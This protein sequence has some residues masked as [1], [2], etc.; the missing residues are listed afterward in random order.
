MKIKE[1]KFYNSVKI[2]NQELLVASNVPGLNNRPAY[3]IE[4]K[5]RIIKITQVATGEITYTGLYNTVW[6]TELKDE[7]VEVRPP[8]TKSNVIK[9]E[10]KNRGR[11]VPKAK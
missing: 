3:E 2:G 6:F 5:E 8:D 10:D 9:V 1:I 7:V 11:Q 4:I